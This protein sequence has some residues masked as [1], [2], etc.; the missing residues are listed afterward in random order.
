MR[1]GLSIFSRGEVPRSVV[2]FVEVVRL[3][4][5]SMSCFPR[6][7]FA[8]VVDHGQRSSTTTVSFVANVS[9]RHGGGGGYGV[10]DLPYDEPSGS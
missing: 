2:F 4:F 3:G 6:R 7:A 5:K 9:R 8:I 1:S 10:R